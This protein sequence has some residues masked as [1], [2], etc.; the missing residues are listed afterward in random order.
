MARPK[1]RP[2]VRA[3]SERSRPFE[4]FQQRLMAVHA[5][6]FTA[7]D[8]TM[9]QA[10]LLYVVDGAR[11]ELTM[12]EIAQRLGRHDLDRERR[13]RPPR[14]DR[15]AQPRSTTRPIGARSASRSRR[16][17]VETLEHMRELSTRQLRSLFDSHRR[18]RPRRSS[19]APS[20]SSPTRRPA[21]RH[22]PPPGA[23]RDPPLAAR[24]L[25]AERHA[26]ARR[27]PSSS[28]ASSPGAASSRSSCR[29]SR[30]RS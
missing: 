26:P 5:P 14:V 16:S 18:R 13:R 23:T 8:L 29:T 3:W 21:D 7:L 12:S 20:G 25:E 19:S 24:H 28:P 22:D 4:A 10:K 30:S 6:E 15:A 1:Q 11:G 27:A 9:A 17:G 2:R